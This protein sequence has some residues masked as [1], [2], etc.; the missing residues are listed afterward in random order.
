MGEERT[1]EIGRRQLRLRANGAIGNR[2][3]IFQMGSSVESVGGVGL[4]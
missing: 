3:R 2:N 4:G 1:N